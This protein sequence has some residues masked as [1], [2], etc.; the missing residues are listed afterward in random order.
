M[1]YLHLLAPELCLIPPLPHRLPL[2]FLKLSNAVTEWVEYQQA[3][4]HSYEQ[5]VDDDVDRV[6]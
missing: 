4:E 1:S 6:A 5:D 3:E 2:L